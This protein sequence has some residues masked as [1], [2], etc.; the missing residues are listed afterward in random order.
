MKNLLIEN[1]NKKILFRILLFIVVLFGV[2]LFMENDF[3][4]Y[5]RPIGRVIASS[6]HYVKTVSQSNDQHTYREKHYTQT[7]KC[8]IKNG[9]YKGKTVTVQNQYTASQVYDTKYEKN[10]FLFIDNIRRSESGLRGNEAGTKRDTLIITVLSAL[11]G[12]FLLVGGRRG[13]LTIFSLALNMICFYFALLLYTKGV[14][15]LV[16][17]VP[18]T[19]FFTAMLLFFMYGRNEKTWLAFSATLLSVAV[20]VLLAAA[21]I[22]SGP[23]VD[24]DFM[25]YLPQPY[26]QMDVNFIFLSELMIGCLG[27]VMDVVVTMIMTMN[28]IAETGGDLSRRALL[29]SCRSVGDDLAGTMI[30]LMFFT[31]IAARIPAFLLFLRNGIQ[32]HTILRYQ[33]YFELTRFLTG[34]IGIVTAI[35]VS[36]GIAVLYYQKKKQRL[37]AE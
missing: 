15:I 34:S 9:K 6:D 5:Q 27:A 4:L 17:M 26:E 7:L 11:F 8:R 20:T 16:S 30:T 21:A 18:L 25:E 22:I 10:D 2:W 12:L 3:F 31:N 37:E 14:N 36:A 13:A 32:F 33:V 19:A 1:L 28:Q 23:R 35:P 24:Y 29:R